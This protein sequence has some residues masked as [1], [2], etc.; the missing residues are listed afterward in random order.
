MSLISAKTTGFA[1]AALL[2]TALAMPS[3]AVSNPLLIIDDF[4][5]SQ[6]ID[7]SGG[8]GTVTGTEQEVGL[9]GTIL[10]DYRDVILQIDQASQNPNNRVL[11]SFWDGPDGQG[12][13][14]Y[15]NDTGY[16]T[17]LELQWDGLDGNGT[18]SNLR[19]LKAN[20]FSAT[21]LTMNG[22]VDSIVVETFSVDQDTEVSFT[23][24]SGENLA[25]YG[26]I[27][28]E[29]DLEP[30][31]FH[32]A[33][34]D[35]VPGVQSYLFDNGSYSVVEEMQYDQR[36][37]ARSQVQ[38]D[39]TQ[40]TGGADFTQITAIRMYIAGAANLDVSLDLIGASS[41]TEIP[42]PAAAGLLGAGLLGYG[43]LRRRR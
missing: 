6:T 38:A 30:S 39:Y 35:F 29:R 1:A 22:H 33:F 42:A 37:S 40:V 17:L 13:L 11:V 21:D 19:N 41:E 3:A 9:T 8:E 32:L 16:V 43:L 23:V 5:T 26:T 27:E 15:S 25:S 28:L 2:T 14:D 4:K 24:W 31:T 18:G 34:D 36:G 12:L 7:T 20:G 10:G